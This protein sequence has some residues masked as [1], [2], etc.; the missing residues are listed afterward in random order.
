MKSSFTSSQ[1]IEELSKALDNRDAFKPE[2]IKGSGKIYEKTF[3]IDIGDRYDHWSDD[4]ESLNE[5]GFLRSYD[6]LAADKPWPQGKASVN[7]N[8]WLKYFNV[9]SKAIDM[10]AGSMYIVKIEPIDHVAKEGIRDLPIEKRHCLYKDE[11]VSL[12]KLTVATY[13]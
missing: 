11:K 9:R 13:C 4:P 2:K 10:V 6:G 3:W 5:P 12:L 7:V 8:Q 1:R